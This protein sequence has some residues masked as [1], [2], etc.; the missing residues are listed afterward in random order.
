MNT[1]G[2]VVFELHAVCGTKQWRNER[3]VEE[4]RAAS[5]VASPKKEKKNN[6]FSNES[7]GKLRS[8]THIHLLPSFDFSFIYSENLQHV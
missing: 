3:K 1:F 6:Y 8:D 4:R 7:G 2:F 5:H